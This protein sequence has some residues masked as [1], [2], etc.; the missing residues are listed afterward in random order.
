METSVSRVGVGAEREDERELAQHG[1]G[2]GQ[3]LEALLM[4]DT[5]VSALNVMHMTMVYVNVIYM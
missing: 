4:D 1:R 5:S 2:R 3:V